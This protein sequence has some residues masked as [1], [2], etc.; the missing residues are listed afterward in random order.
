MTTRKNA[1]VVE[2]ENANVETTNANDETTN[3]NANV[4]VRE[5]VKTN[6]TNTYKT[7]RENVNTRR[8][9][10]FDHANCNHRNDKNDRAKCRKLMQS[11]ATTYVYNAQNND[12]SNNA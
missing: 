6:D 4:V 1:N 7:M 12:A 5:I 3:A 2:I 11:N 9:V 8:N 10:R